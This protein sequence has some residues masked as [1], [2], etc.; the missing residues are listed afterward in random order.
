MIPPR[1]KTPLKAN[2]EATTYAI[3]AIE[4]LLVLMLHIVARV[5]VVVNE[6][7]VEDDDIGIRV[8]PCI[9][10]ELVVCSSYSEMHERRIGDSERLAFRDHFHLAVL[11]RA[12]NRA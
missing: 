8:R 9:I 12:Q 10:L 6:H 4:V 3:H 2:W 1:H 11:K 5:Y 7:G